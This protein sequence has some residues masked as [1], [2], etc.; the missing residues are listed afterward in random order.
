M[1]LLLPL[2]TDVQHFPQNGSQPRSRQT[3]GV[4]MVISPQVLLPL[5]TLRSHEFDVRNAVPVGRAGTLSRFHRRASC[6]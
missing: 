6:V 2:I 5:V 1:R 3:Y 4:S